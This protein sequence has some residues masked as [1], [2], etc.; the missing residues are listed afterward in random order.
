MVMQIVDVE[1]YN[2]QEI[3]LLL[4]FVVAFVRYIS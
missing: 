1:L 4:S 2:L 3:L